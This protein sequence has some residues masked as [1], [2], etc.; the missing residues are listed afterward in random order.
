[1]ERSGGGK[2]REREGGYKGAGERLRMGGHIDGRTKDL[3]TPGLFR[4]FVLIKLSRLSC[5]PPLRKALDVATSHLMPFFTPEETKALDASPTSTQTT[6]ATK[7]TQGQPA[8]S[9]R[10]HPD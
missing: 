10:P 3:R 5:P 8:H 9:L 7:N 6:S 2:A 1:M 4:V